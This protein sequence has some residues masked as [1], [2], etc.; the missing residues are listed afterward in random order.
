MNKL[1]TIIILAIIS[2]SNVANAQV[3]NW[4]WAK[5]SGGTGDVYG[6]STTTDAL[7][8]IYVTG[9]YS[10]SSITFGTF[11][12][13]NAGDADV[14]I[15][16]YDAS[17]NVT[18]AKSAGGTG[19]DRARSI[20]TDA[21]G[22]VYVTGMYGDSPSIT[23]GTFTLT[24]ALAV[25]DDFFIVKY[26]ASG[27]VI[28]ARG[29]GGMGNDYGYSTTSDAFGN[30]YVTGFYSSSTITFGTFTLTDAVGYYEMFIVKYDVLGNVLWAKGAGATGNGYGYSTATDATGNVYVTGCYTYPSITFGTFTLTNTDTIGRNNMFIVKYD[31]SGNELWAKSA[32]G[33][34]DDF[35]GYSTATDASGN[36]YVTGLYTSST[37]TFGTF[38]LTNADPI[39]NLGDIFIVKYDATGNVLWAKGEGGTGYDGANSISTDASGNVYVTGFYA[40]STITFGT[41]TLTNA[42]PIGLLG[43]MFIVKYDAS[44]QVLWAKRAGGTEIDKGNSTATDAS[45][46]VYVTGL[47]TSPSINFG[48]FTLT[49]AGNVNMFIAKLDATT[50]I[51]ENAFDNGII[52]FP[53]PIHDH[54]TINYGNY[55]ALDGYTIKIT[56]SLSQTVFTTKIRQQQSYIDLSTWRNGIYFVHLI[57]AT[58]NI[59]EIKK[60]IIQ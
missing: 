43:D 38:T 28:W 16:K 35:G 50:G 34:G 59:V 4:A 15:V 22:N 12:L 42:D 19:G 13:T 39:G 2:W 29:A 24:N 23:F 31:S 40:S 14:Y 26:D 51:E 25:N 48:T 58:N 47:Y 10:S 49:N 54:I 11:T 44:G 36:V 1:Y 5:S 8:N 17:G 9:H 30:V 57:D 18:W 7:G 32:G 53:N 33:W 37:I 60:I 52:I 3:T 46:N 20:S 55:S 21:S 27:N 45:G 41:F 6:Y 56:N